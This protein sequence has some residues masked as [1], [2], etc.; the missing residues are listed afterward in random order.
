MKCPPD[1]LLVGKIGAPFGVRGWLKI[2]SFTDPITNLLNYKPWHISL[3]QHWPETTL[4]AGRVHGKGLVVQMQGVADRDKALEFRG[5]QIAVPSRV[6]P[7]LDGDD[8]YWSDLIGMRVK[9]EQGLEIGRIEDVFETGA[10][11]V[12]VVRNPQ[13]TEPI[14]IPYVRDHYILSID[15]TTRIVIVDWLDSY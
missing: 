15:K 7:P 10:N 2:H 13:Q 12:I 9:N 6:L 8:V 5:L 14:L 11:D 4:L 1:L 3:N